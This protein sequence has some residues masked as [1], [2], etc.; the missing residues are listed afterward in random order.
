MQLAV[1]GVDEKR[2]VRALQ[3]KWEVGASAE[4]I[5]AAQHVVNMD[6]A[7][8]QCPACGASFANPGAGAQ[9]VCPGCGLHL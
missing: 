1:A 6:A 8:L 4:E 7:N 9:T 5:R 2:A 3:H